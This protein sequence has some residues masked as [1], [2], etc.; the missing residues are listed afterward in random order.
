M[1]LLK[2]EYKKGCLKLPPDLK[3]IKSYGAFRSWLN[4][5]YKKTWI[6][7]LNKKSRNMKINID[8]LGK[9]LKRPPIGET[10]LKEYDGEF[11]AYEYLDHNTNSK[12]IMKLPV[13]EFISRLIS[14]IP[15]KNF[16]NIRYYGFL[17][18]R[19][20]GTLLPMV[21]NLLDMKQILYA[22]VYGTW[23]DMIKDSFKY[24]PLKCPFC[25][26]ILQLEEIVFG[27]ASSIMTSMHKEIANGYFPLL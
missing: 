16:R 23:R 26:T 4:Q 19:V 13:L 9:Y 7:H 17:A 11:V 2:E 24:D 10:R 12:D 27:N 25:K 1:L 6:V 3:L 18:N 5:H 20:R 15:D 22:K 14:H 21:Y 8:Y